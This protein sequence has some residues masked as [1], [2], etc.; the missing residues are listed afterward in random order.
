ML[1]R[2]QTFAPLNLQLMRSETAPGCQAEGEA[3]YSSTSH[4]AEVQHSPDVISW[5]IPSTEIVAFA[6]GLP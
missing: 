1:S 2:L 4:F 5:L 3:A 6:I